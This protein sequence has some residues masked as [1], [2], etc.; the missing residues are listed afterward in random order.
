MKIEV[1]HRAFAGALIKKLNE[2]AKCKRIIQRSL[3]SVSVRREASFKRKLQQ[4]RDT[5]TTE[6]CFSNNTTFDLEFPNFPE[7]SLVPQHQWDELFESAF[8]AIGD[9]CIEAF[10]DH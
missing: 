1:N 3:H 10:D 8:E 2:H 5:S 4:L 9:T 6:E 7:E